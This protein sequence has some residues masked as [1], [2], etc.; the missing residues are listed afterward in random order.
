[1]SDESSEDAPKKKKKKATEEKKPAPK[2]A[3]LDPSNSAD[4]KILKMKTVLNSCGFV[5]R[6][7]N[8]YDDK[9]E[10]AEK[11][12][13]MLTENGLK[14]SMSKAEVRYSGPELCYGT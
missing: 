4:A 8:K 1:M 2:K 12:Q 6:F 13:E 14:I 5:V 7:M 9:S 11:L 3:K 10:L